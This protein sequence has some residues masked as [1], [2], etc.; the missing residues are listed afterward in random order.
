MQEITKLMVSDFG[1]KRLG[2]DF[3]GYNVNRR[4]SLSFHHLIIPKKD[5]KM[6]GLG[7]GYTYWNGVI[8]VQETSHDYLHLIQK[9]DETTFDRIT[10]QM[11]EEKAKGYLDKKNLMQIKELLLD[12]EDRHR[13]LHTSK[14]KKLIKREYVTGRFERF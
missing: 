11:I 9:Y 3:M 10:L 13:G 8:L 7:D 12:F 5:C 6:Y 14:G 1:I 2:Y 4:S